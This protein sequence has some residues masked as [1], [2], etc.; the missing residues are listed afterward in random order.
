VRWEQRDVVA[1]P[2]PPGRWRLILCRNLAIYLRPQ[3][4]DALH[5]KLAEALAAR[6]VLM[7]GRSERISDPGMVGL[8]TAGPH[9]YRRT[10]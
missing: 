4:R 3:A 8:E 6:G 10:A 7:L 9:C 5:R 2:T 1:A